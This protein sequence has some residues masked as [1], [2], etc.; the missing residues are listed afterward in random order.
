MDNPEDFVR[1]EI[2]SALAREEM[3]VIPVMLDQAPVPAAEALPPDL[4][5]LARRNAVRLTHERFKS[6]VGGLIRALE[7]ALDD[8]AERRAEAAARAKRAE[9]AAAADQAAAARAAAREEQLAT[10]GPEELRRAEEL[11]NWEFIKGKDDPDWVRDHLARF[12]GGVSEPWARERLEALA[13][14]RLSGGDALTIEQVEAFLDE[15][16]KGAHAAEAKAQQAKLRAAAEAEAQRAQLAGEAE[17]AWAAVQG[18]RRRQ[19][20]AR[21][22]REIPRHRARRRGDPPRPRPERRLDPPRGC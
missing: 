21:L 13:W 7:T 16:P 3:R 8:A 5:P 2:A 12:P 19:N 20:P 10:L 4:A 14:A 9:E 18:Q 22:R 11:A 17:T 15:F 6:D 1:I